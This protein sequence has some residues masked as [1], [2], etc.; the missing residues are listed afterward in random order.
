M[1]K[2][3]FNNTDQIVRLGVF[4]MKPRTCEIVAVVG[5]GIVIGFYALA[6][7]S[8]ALELFANFGLVAYMGCAALVGI[9]VFLRLGRAKMTYVSLGFA[10]GL[11]FWVLGL[12]IYS[13]SY[14][15]VDTGLSFLSL[16][17]IFYFL[18]YPAMISG[19][20]GM[21]HFCRHSL[22]RRDWI[23]VVVLGLLL[24]LL[25]IAYVIP[26]SISYLTSP[27]EVI[28]TVLYPTL[29]IAVFLL[30]LPMFFAMRKSVFE[31]A[32]AFISLGAV[33]LAL[34]DLFYAALNVA[35]LYYDGHPIDLLL[36]F[37]CISVGYGFCRERANLESLV[38]H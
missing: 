32:F 23:V 29:D 30:L 8:Y 34:G 12:L 26:S 5:A 6:Q 38:S 16:A 37:G 18:T 33:L 4:T 31:R 2:D 21:F 35:Y 15:I 25:D 28:V 7:G 13:Y 9:V 22:I 1:Q 10:M 36:F 24:Y 27:L 17:D 11:L 14:Y 19:A 20:L 3:T